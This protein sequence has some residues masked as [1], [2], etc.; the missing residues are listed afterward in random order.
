MSSHTLVS[1]RFSPKISLLNLITTV[2]ISPITVPHVGL[3][4]TPVELYHR[5]QN[6]PFPCSCTAARPFLLAQNLDTGLS[7]LHVPE[8]LHPMSPLNEVLLCDSTKACVSV[9]C[10]PASSVSQ[11]MI[12]EVLGWSAQGSSFQL[13]GQ[14]PAV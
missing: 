7:Q 4:S 2:R 3:F 9:F 1:A 8:A 5:L 11:L 14:G 12:A 13:P 6:P 10:S